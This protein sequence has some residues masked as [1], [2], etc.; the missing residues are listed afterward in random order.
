VTNRQT[1][2]KASP[3]GKRRSDPL[4]Y[5]DPSET[6][7]PSEFYEDG[8]VHEFLALLGG[9]GLEPREDSDSID[10]SRKFGTMTLAPE[11]VPDPLP[12]PFRPEDRADARIADPV[13]MYLR[14]MGLVSLL[15]REDETEIAMRIE[16]GEKEVISLIMRTAVGMDALADIRR[17]LEAD[18]LRLKEVVK[19]AEDDSEG[20]DEAR[21][22]DQVIGLIR[23]IEH[24][25]RNHASYVRSHSA[26]EVP[27]RIRAIEKHKE[28]CLMEI[29]EL[30]LKLGLVKRQYDGMV[31]RLRG[32]D[33]S[34]RE[35]EALLAD[36]CAR[37]GVTP[38]ELASLPQEVMAGD[39][40]PGTGTGPEA[41]AELVAQARRHRARLAE[42]EGES[43][44]GREELHSILL[45]IERSE[46]DAS[47][48]K[49][50]L[51]EANLRLVVS[52]AKKYTNRG[53]HFLD[54]IQEGNIGLMRAVDKFDHKRGFKFSTYATW[55]I[56]Q[57]ITR[58]IADQ[59]RTIRI[60]VHMIETINKLMRASR[61][62]TQELGRE[63]VP[64]ELAE[65]MEM[66]LDKVRKVLKISKE[67]ISLETPIG[68]DEDTSLGDFITDSES[69]SPHAA[70]LT[71]DL[72]EQIRKA[73]ATLTDKEAEVIRQRFGIDRSTDLTLE[74]VGRR[75]GVTR[76]RIRQIE[77]K[78]ITK[79]RHPGRGKELKYFVDG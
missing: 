3:R 29:E 23:D 49:R 57:A 47:D 12:E 62:L 72:Q 50:H 32:L 21:R 43:K 79:L 68:D 30:L 60:P 5:Q 37:L 18:Q 16:R 24:K 19:E 46:R 77:A 74:E 13:K 38:D 40:V 6:A 8:A 15:S 54:L 48:A 44:M 70:V 69:V 58:A 14:E 34:L 67:P 64:E 52:I 9:T 4:D 56:R 11:L 61:T 31:D 20:R 41:R 59:A 25:L 36:G 45:T 65:R 53:L 10:A 39:G 78:A 28:K 7:S 1:I 51:I 75:F 26:E 76:E 33:R 17:S 22:R 42:L 63:P 2:R 35:T 73:L 55:W 27:Q 71:L 66:P